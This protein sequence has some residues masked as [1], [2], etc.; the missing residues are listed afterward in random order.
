MLRHTSLDKLEKLL[1][2]LLLYLLMNAERFSISIYYLIFFIKVNIISPFEF[3]E[4]LDQAE[5]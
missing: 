1:L 3:A 4:D 2:M 5:E